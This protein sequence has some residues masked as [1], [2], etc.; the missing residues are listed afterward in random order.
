M[1][2][3]AL[4]GRARVDGI[5]D[6]HEVHIVPLEATHEIDELLDASAEAIKLPDDEGVAVP[7]L[8]ERLEEPRAVSDPSAGRVLV[9]PF[10]PSP[11]QRLVLDVETLVVRRDT[12]VAD[13]HIRSSGGRFSEPVEDRTS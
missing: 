8:V 6:A 5:G 7:E 10:A 3:E 9:D 2:E 13:E 1:K 12:G 11:S 4:G